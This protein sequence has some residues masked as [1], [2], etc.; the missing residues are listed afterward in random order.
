[1]SMRRVIT[2]VAAIAALAGNVWAQEVDQEP[3]RPSPALLETVQPMGLRISVGDLRWDT[4]DA[5]GMPEWQVPVACGAAAGEQERLASPMP[6]DRWLFGVLWGDDVAEPRSYIQAIPKVTLWLTQPETG[7]SWPAALGAVL[8]MP[9]V[10]G[11]SG[12]AV[13]ARRRFGVGGRDGPR[14]SRRG[15]PRD[16]EK[17]GHEGSVG[18]PVDRGRGEAPAVARLQLRRDGG[19]RGWAGQ[20]RTGIRGSR[21]R[22]VLIPDGTGPASLGRRRDPALAVTVSR[23]SCVR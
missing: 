23:P 15:G 3:E 18:C 17:Q 14:R 6:G 19:A 16:A 9:D 11:A 5:T 8:Q 12:A 10:H 4:N 22:T 1:M 7:R 2:G 13:V 21:S 20:R